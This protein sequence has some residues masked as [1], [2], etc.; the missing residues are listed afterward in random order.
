SLPAASPSAV[1]SPA[2]PASPDDPAAAPL[3][4]PFKPASNPRGTSALIAT[5]AD[6]ASA[7]NAPQRPATPA[8]TAPLTRMFDPAAAPVEPAAAAG[9]G[10][11]ASAPTGTAAAQPA[12]SAPATANPTPAL[13][14]P[15]QPLAG[16]AT[17]TPALPTR[18]AA[19]PAA[20]AEAGPGLAPSPSGALEETIKL[21]AQ[22]GFSR[23]RITLRPAELGSVSVVLKASA[24]GVSASV[25]ADTPEAARLL[26]GSGHEL[27][28]RLEAQ[29][30]QLLGLSV[31]VSHDAPSGADRQGQAP[32]GGPG[33]S[34]ASPELPDEN[35]QPV[36][37]IEL[38]GGVLVDVLA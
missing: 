37:T 19:A 34:A 23:A 18:S 17:A 13:P 25:L 6:P 28:N 31:S 11:R 8:T 2:A 7:L 27:R 35:P 5:P 20:L 3:P 29:G 24:A 38:G 32:A 14:T 10:D 9:T 21:A 33:P 15:A 4:A 36:R 22:H 30:L 16:A 1:P 12:A 26:E